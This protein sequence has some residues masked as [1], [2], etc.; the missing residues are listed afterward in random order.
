MRKRKTLRQLSVIASRWMAW[1]SQLTARHGRW[2]DVP[3]LPLVLSMPASSRMLLLQ[4]KWLSSYLRIQSQ[5]NLYFSPANVWRGT[6]PLDAPHLA[7]IKPQIKL[8]SFIAAIRSSRMPGT[9]PRT[10]LASEHQTLLRSNRGVTASLTREKLPQLPMTLAMARTKAEHLSTMLHRHSSM[11]QEPGFTEVSSLLTRRV[12]RVSEV[13][14]DRPQL[15]LRKEFQ[16]VATPQIPAEAMLEQGS[17]ERRS[18]SHNVPSLAMSVDV[19]QL[20][21]QVMK[22]IDR[23]VIARRERMGQI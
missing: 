16:F 18:S 23:R 10:Q 9:V 5:L 4:Q 6:T 12:Q 20:A 2:A 11:R 19:E 17:F 13:S 15:G 21:N 1:A 14:L 3:T 22:Q 7:F 8:L